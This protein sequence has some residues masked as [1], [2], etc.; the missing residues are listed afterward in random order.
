MPR[1]PRAFAP[2]SFSPGGDARPGTMIASQESAGSIACVG[3]Y[4]HTPVGA[5]MNPLSEICPRASALSPATMRTS[6]E[7]CRPWNDSRTI[8]AGTSLTHALMRFRKRLLPVLVLM[9]VAIELVSALSLAALSQLRGIT[10][11][12]ALTTLTE[13]QKQ[14]LR[15]FLLEGSGSDFGQDP[16]LG[17]VP[18][19]DQNAAG[20]R[21]D[22]EYTIEPPPGTLRI[23]AFGDSFIYGS[24][25][26]L[27]QSWLKQLA[28]LEPSIE[29]LNYGV[30]AYGL[31]QAYLRYRR[32]AREYRPH[33]VLIGYMSENIAR[34][35]NVFRAFYTSSYRDVIFTK[36]RFE[37]RRGEL[38]LLANPIAT[39]ADHER[40]LNHDTEVL[41]ELGQHDYHYQ[42]TYQAGPFD[43]LPS[44]RFAKIFS[45]YVRKSLLDPI[46]SVRG[47]YDVDSEAFK[48]TLAIFDAFYREVLTNGA[49]PI[50]VVLPDINDQRHNR[51]KRERRYRPLLDTFKQR[52]YRF[53]D[54]L[55]AFEPEESRYS[56]GQLTAAWG[57]FSPLG[58]RLAARYVLQQLRDWDY[59]DVDTV[60]DAMRAEQQRLNIALDLVPPAQQ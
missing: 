21:D 22:H 29:V 56:I 27:S 32:V 5:R 25:V 51:A 53:I 55:D 33:I 7:K 10:Y 3:L 20:M 8:L 39:R 45:Y 12:P 28:N 59:L 42:I 4:V 46:I 13:T 31:D 37:L 15:K 48:V 24:D 14:R 49:M 40:L 6:Q 16:V 1:P 60:R 23:S 9:W 44:V 43:V 35:V 52:E 2:A 26:P 58:G 47:V 41:R 19:A 36:P 57:H 34:D 30:G 11:D 50:V 18:T 17:W 38:R 54:V